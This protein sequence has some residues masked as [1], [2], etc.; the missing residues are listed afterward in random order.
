[1]GVPPTA[2]AVAAVTATDVPDALAPWERA[3]DE[4]VVRAVTARDTVDETLA[5]VR[6][7]RPR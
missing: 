2:T 5:L 7:A 6:A 1:M 3:L 4:V